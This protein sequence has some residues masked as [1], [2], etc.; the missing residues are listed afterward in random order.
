MNAITRMDE[1]AVRIELD[2]MTTDIAAMLPPGVPIERFKRVA[3]TAV[4][5]VPKLLQ[6]YPPS[7]F[8]SCLKAA[9]DGLLPDGR[10][11]AIVPRWNGK[12]RRLEA[13]WQPMVAGI[14]AKAKRAGNVV[15]LVAQVVYEGEAFAYD[16]GD[17]ERITHRRDMSK[18][19]H[20][21]EVGVYAIAT[22]KDGTKEREAMTWQ[23]VQ[24]VR[25]AS[26]G[27]GQKGPWV[28][29]P[30]E[31]A[32]KTVIRRLSKRLPSL[33]VG[34]D[35][36]HKAIERVDDLYDFGRKPTLPP[37]SYA[38]ALASP[39]PEQE[40]PR[41]QSTAEYLGDSLPPD[42]PAPSP[43]PAR[44]VRKRLDAC[45]TLDDVAKVDAAWQKACAKKEPPAVLAQA[46]R[47]MIAERAAQLQ[48]QDRDDM[49]QGDDMAGALAD[50]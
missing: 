39:E 44:E 25:A 32:R 27:G 17:D 11:G 19:R 22:L 28:D 34:D 9:S 33:D 1:G 16:M 35:D 36:L 14:Q 4:Q 30:D 13:S 43:D 12:E 21:K 41:A 20:G 26:E 31:M 8:N 49:D 3:L 24:D 47:D 50:E 29:W 37:V 2:R 7:L 18:V 23:Q 6:C 45:Q 40:Q 48:P 5:Q 42:E 10:E 46:V 38:P 15:S